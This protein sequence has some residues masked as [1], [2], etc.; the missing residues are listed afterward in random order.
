MQ[1]KVANFWYRTTTV[2]IRSGVGRVLA[3][4]W[5]RCMP[6][7]PVRRKVFG[8]DIYFDSRD[9][10]FVWYAARESLEEAENLPETLSKF[11]GLFWDVGANAGTYSLWMASRGNQVVS[12]DISPKAISY[13]RKSAERNGLKNVTGVP[14][15][16]STEAVAYNAP[17]TATADNQLPST[18]QN[19]GDTK[20]ITYLEAAAQFGVP[21]LIKMDI[22]GHEEAFLRSA[23]F[24]KWLIDNNVA[25]VLELHKEAYRDLLWKDRPMVQLSQN[26]VFFPP[27]PDRKEA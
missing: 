20:A 10:P 15:A 5:H 1:S 24:K 9:H 2:L 26:L 12:F 25:W 11:Q 17:Q 8:L 7:F 13:I 19:Q 23:E 16:F 4:I 3:S 14:R 21:K 6:S 18:G 22:E 27:T